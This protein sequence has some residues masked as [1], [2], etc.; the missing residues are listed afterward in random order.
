MAVVLMI[1]LEIL[2]GRSGCVGKSVTECCRPSHAAIGGPVTFTST[3]DVAST[4]CIAP[5]IARLN[6]VCSIYLRFHC[7]VMDISTMVRYKYFMR[8]A[9]T[10]RRVH[11]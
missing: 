9:R 4:L 3:K 8:D 7:V 10:E 2:Q 11:D 5:E 6:G 1:T